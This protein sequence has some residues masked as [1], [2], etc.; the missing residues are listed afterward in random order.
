MYKRQELRSYRESDKPDDQNKFVLLKLAAL[1]HDVG[2]YTTRSVDL[3]GR[4]RFLGHSETGAKISDLILTNLRMP[5]KSINLVNSLVENHLRPGQLSSKRQLPTS[6]ALYRYYR[7]LEGNSIPLIILYMADV[8]AAAGPK[9][10]TIEWSNTLRYVNH[11]I[12][13]HTTVSEQNRFNTLLTGHEIMST[14]GLK[15]GKIIGDLLEKIN[16]SQALGQLR[17]KQDA[18]DMVSCLLSSGEDF[19]KEY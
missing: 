7:D 16:E 19:A 10:S 14:F 11:I 1:L 12:G 13:Y 2:K 8:L 15:S 9:L 3:N 18:L 5:K 6:R 4:I 17:S